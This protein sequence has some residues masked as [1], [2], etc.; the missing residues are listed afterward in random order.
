M[1]MHRRSVMRLPGLRRW[2]WPICI[3][4]K[5]R[6]SMP[7]SRL[8][9]SAPAM[10]RS[11]CCRLRQVYR[12]VRYALHL[13]PGRVVA[14]DV[15]DVFEIDGGRVVAALGD[16]SGAGLGAGLV[17]ASV[18]SFLR[19]GFAHDGDPARVVAE[20]NVHLCAQ[21]GERSIRHALAG[22]FRSL[23]F[24]LPFR[25]C[26]T[27]PCL[28]PRCGSVQALPTARLHS[29]GHR[30][31]GAIRRRAAGAWRWRDDRALQRWRHRTARCDRACR[32]ARTDWRNR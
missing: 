14:G 4:S 23:W 31:A 17:M 1:L 5:A 29:A 7:P 2:P 24:A 3:G 20:L 19:A 25:R 8:I 12:S 10:C 6:A 30:C 26:R 32:G 28:A 27:W 22:R 16:V 9:W 11:A 21:T 18:Q 13:H 15:V